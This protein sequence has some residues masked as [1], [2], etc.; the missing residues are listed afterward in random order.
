[1]TA[2]KF[3]DMFAPFSSQPNEEWQAL[4]KAAGEAAASAYVP[5]SHRPMGAAAYADDGRIVTGCSVENA[6]IGLTLCAECGLVSAFVLSGGGGL[7][8]IVVVDG[9]GQVIPPC[10]RCRQ[11]L[12]EHGGPELMIWTPRGELSLAQLMPLS[13]GPE[14]LTGGR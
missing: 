5:Y 1:M 8:K 10:G 4:L 2:N 13:W 11:L 7:T 9:A 6:S 12:L 14:Q 3:A